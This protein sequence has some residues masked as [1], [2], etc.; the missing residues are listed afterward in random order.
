MIMKAT[1]LTIGGV[2][3]ALAFL[4]FAV[5]LMKHEGFAGPQCLGVLL[6]FVG[7]PIFLWGLFWS[8][9]KEKKTE[10]DDYDW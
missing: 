9:N 10:C 6:L 4:I 3:T 1:A 8:E 7:L 5:T 2:L